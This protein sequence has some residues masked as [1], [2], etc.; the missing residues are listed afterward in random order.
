[1]T[2]AEIKVVQQFRSGT[3]NHV[4]LPAGTYFCGDGCY[5][6]DDELWQSLCE[7]M[8]PGNDSK[9]FNVFVE[10]DGLPAFFWGTIH[11][12]GVYAG[13]SNGQHFDL[14][15]DS[16]SLSLVSMKLVEQFNTSTF[17]AHDRK[18]G[19]VVTLPEA[20]TI[21]IDEKANVNSQFPHHGLVYAEVTPD[22]EEWDY[23]E[24]EDEDE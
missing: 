20:V 15:V 18:C 10:I 16:G 19:G 22:E 17:M 21:E 8:F 4:T 23:E 9:G 7:V 12:D 6:L 2:K 11:G 13:V 14:P 24:D 1:M 5:V 3:L